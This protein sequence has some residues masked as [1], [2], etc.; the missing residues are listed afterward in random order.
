MPYF[1]QLS[2]LFI[3]IPKNGGTT[4]ENL[5]FSLIGIPFDQNPYNP[6]YFKYLFGFIP[7][8]THSS[9]HCTYQ[10]LKIHKD[11]NLDEIETIFTVVRN[12][13]ER[14]V[15]AFWFNSMCLPKPD[16]LPKP[17]DDIE[18][19]KIKFKNFIIKFYDINNNYDNHNL[20]QYDFLINNEG[21]IDDKIKIL[22]FE[23]FDQDIK[24]IIKFDK[25]PHLNKSH[26]PYKFYEY[27]DDESI[28]MTLQ[29]YDK[30]FTTFNYSRVCN[31]ITG[32]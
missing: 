12:P 1:E 5:Y 28:A 17:E 9:Q 18:I 23:N 21:M 10:E 3:H 31:L 15:S 13:F 4:I 19:L 27:Y 6:E 32:M 29:H 26:A 8:Y 20:S 24:T 16:E 25:L 7:N 30:D 2:T 14:V 22:R 11:L